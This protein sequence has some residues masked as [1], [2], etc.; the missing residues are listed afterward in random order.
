VDNEKGKAMSIF[1][2]LGFNDRGGHKLLSRLHPDFLSALSSGLMDTADLLSTVSQIYSGNMEDYTPLTLERTRQLIR[3]ASSV[4]LKSILPTTDCFSVP[5]EGYGNLLPAIRAMRNAAVP[6]A[7]TMSILFHGEPGTGKSHFALCARDFCHFQRLTPEVFTDPTKKL[8][9]EICE[10]GLLIDEVDELYAKHPAE[11]H[12][13]LDDAHNGK[14]GDIVVVMTTNHF[15]LLKGTPLVRP[16][17]VDRIIELGAPTEKDVEKFFSLVPK[18]VTRKDIEERVS[19]PY[20]MA[21]LGQAVK[22]IYMEKLIEGEI[23]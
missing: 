4:V 3:K 23:V 17:R 16:G 19:K 11:L 8:E 12:A 15:D 21:K 13:L 14:F 7:K 18:P 5:L 22:D 20:T 1:E 6:F 10:T 9:E 2:K